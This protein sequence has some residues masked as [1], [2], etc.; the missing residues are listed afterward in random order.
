MITR[1]KL[2][3]K[4]HWEDNYLLGTTF[5][6]DIFAKYTT[7]IYT[8]LN[9]LHSDLD[10][11]KD[12]FKGIYCPYNIDVIEFLK[13]IFVD[14][15]ITFRSVNKP[16]SN[17]ILTGKV[18][19]IYYYL[20]HDDEFYISVRFDN[21]EEHLIQGNKII[22]IEDYDAENKPLHLEVKMKKQAEKY[23]I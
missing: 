23:N 3:E 12:N 9:Y 4:N 6:Y 7:S 16:D 18:I 21:Y 22:V 5:A 1:F 2:F 10:W 11:D 14:K 15:K 20:Y 19:D 13:E 8:I 17:P